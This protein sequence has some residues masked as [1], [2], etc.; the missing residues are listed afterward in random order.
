MGPIDNTSAGRAPAPAY[1]EPAKT[2]ERQVDL[3]SKHGLTLREYGQYIGNLNNL[4]SVF[5][6]GQDV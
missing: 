6:N 1:R 5:S 3:A 4:D 2:D